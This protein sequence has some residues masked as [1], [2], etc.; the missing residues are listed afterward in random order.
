[1]LILSMIRLY[2]CFKGLIIFLI[3]P[4][5]RKGILRFGYRSIFR[6]ML[7]L[8]LLLMGN[9]SLWD[10]LINLIV[11]K[12][13]CLL[14]LDLWRLWYLGRMRSHYA[15]QDLWKINCWQLYR[16]WLKKMTKLAFLWNPIFHVCF[17]RKFKVWIWK[18]NP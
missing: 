18:N 8:L 2:L 13:W 16:N 3:G 17:L 15:F 4:M 11:R 9:L 12:L 14:I 6:R 7:R 1:M 10:I 5:E